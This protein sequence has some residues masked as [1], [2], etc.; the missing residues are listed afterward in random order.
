M[1]G[2]LK[3]YPKSGKNTLSERLL[4]RVMGYVLKIKNQSS[5]LDGFL[6]KSV[7]R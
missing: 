6:K 7:F 1:D 4:P 2:F 5:V 3:A